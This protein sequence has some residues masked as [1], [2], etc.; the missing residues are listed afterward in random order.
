MWLEIAECVDQNIGSCFE[1]IG[2]LCLSN[3]KFVVTNIITSAALW[4]LWKLR[5]SFC[6]QVAQ[7]RDVNFLLQKITGLVHKWKLLC[8]GQHSMELEMRLNRL[9]DAAK[10][11]GRLT[12]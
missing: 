5:N 12:A 7:W 11:F 10:K 4:G 3:K 8:P 2:K 1:S 9:Q 6:F